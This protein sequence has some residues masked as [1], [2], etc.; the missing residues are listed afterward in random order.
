LSVEEQFYIFF[1][2]FLIII[3]KY[4]RQ[5]LVTILFIIFS[6]SLIFAQWS[7]ETDIKI[8]YNFFKFDINF[9]EKFNFYFI[10]SRI[11]EFLI[12]SLLSYFK[13]NSGLKGRKSYSILNQIYPSLGILLILYSFLFFNF[14]KIFHPSVIT[15]IPL[16]GVSLII[17]FS[18][19][20]ELIT[21][22]L[23]SKIFVFFGL[24][25][26]SLY[27][28]HYPIFAFL[29]YSYVF[30]GS[31]L[32][33]LLSV[34]LTI[35]LSILSYYL[36]E[37][38]FRNKNIISIKALTAY[39]LIII[40][41]LL[42]YSFYILKT[43]GIKSRVP[44]ILA[45][46]F[47]TNLDNNLLNRTGGNLK[48]VLLI[49][50]SHSDTL[51][52]HFNKELTKQSYNFYKKNS[53]LYLKN[54]NLFN[55][56]TNLQD[57]NYIEDTKEIDKFLQEHKDLIVVW[58]QR[59]SLLLTEKL[60]D[61]NEGYTEYQNEEDKYLE[62]YL[63]PINF[64]TETLEQRQKYI[65]EGIKSS[66]KNILE[67]GHSLI[68]VY[69]VPEIGFDVQKLIIGQYVFSKMLDKKYEIPIKTISYDVYKNRNKMIFETL[70]D[71]QGPNVY[72]VYPHKSFCNTIIVNRCVVNNNKNIFYY[73]NNHLSLK[74]SEYVVNN[75]MKIIKKIEINK[76]N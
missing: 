56:K 3:I 32:I 29:R 63:Q 57:R 22:I 6:F 51:K 5:H 42:S 48:N 65:I 55:K 38:P 1:P 13:L 68:L 37:R 25:S 61:N 41:I 46:E 24:I 28:W 17:W 40:I 10:Q 49:G 15:L 47:S 70:D 8:N 2:I 50:D 44:N 64:R 53:V 11:F 4:L 20:G 31:I 60:F 45:E 39:I 43:E 9:F 74:G 34:L 30:N 71:I 62:V 76:R 27:L 69:P 19:K 14:G 23:S 16:V 66:A 67:K 12:G 58:H 75:I 33:K 72:K 21:E 54:F 7:S 18:K 52:Y 26:Y 35:I 36:I 73:D 59:W